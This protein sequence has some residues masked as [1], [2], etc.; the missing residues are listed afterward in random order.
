MCVSEG[1]REGDG[2]YK[3]D[4][5]TAEIVLF[6]LTN[7]IHSTKYCVHTQFIHTYMYAH[8]DHR[9]YTLRTFVGYSI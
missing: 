6:V 1:G 3:R 2:M 7:S 5:Y 4:G 8:I 9:Y